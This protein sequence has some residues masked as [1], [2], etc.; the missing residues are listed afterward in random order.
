MARSLVAQPV[1]LCNYNMAIL[2][3]E[4]GGDADFLVGTTNGF[5]ASLNSAPAVATDYVHGGH[6]KSIKYR[7]GFGDGVNTKAGT[8]PIAGTRISFYIYLAALPN[9]TSRFL[10][11]WNA[12][13]S[14]INVRLT[15]AGVLQF[16]SNGI[17]QGT[18]GATLST[19]QWYRISLAFV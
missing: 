15:S 11:D 2:F 3:L 7:P 16:W 18:N 8:T 13:G 19:G 4:P 17:Q 6:K 12:N 1:G 14:Y 10:Q 5:W 9:A